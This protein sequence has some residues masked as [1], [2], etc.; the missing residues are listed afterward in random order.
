MKNI[1]HVAFVFATDS[2]Y[3]ILLAIAN[4]DYMKYKIE[5][6]LKIHEPNLN[7]YEFAI[8][9]CNLLAQNMIPKDKKQR[10]IKAAKEEWKQL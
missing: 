1:K 6:I 9:I 3:P 8:Y 10:I 2:L 5:K 7:K 4:R